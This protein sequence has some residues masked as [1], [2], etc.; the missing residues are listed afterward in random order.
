MDYIRVDHRDF[1]ANGASCLRTRENSKKEEEK[2][3]KR[4]KEEEGDTETERLMEKEDQENLHI[5]LLCIRRVTRL[6]VIYNVY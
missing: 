1:K 6:W 3:E 4:K 5:R 2:E